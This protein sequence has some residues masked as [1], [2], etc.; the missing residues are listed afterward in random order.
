MFVVVEAPSYTYIYI[1]FL[2]P[3]AIIFFPP[4]FIENTT[5]GFPTIGNVWLRLYAGYVM[6]S[7]RIV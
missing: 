5:P 7:H 2:R 3:K 4:S 6:C 1:F